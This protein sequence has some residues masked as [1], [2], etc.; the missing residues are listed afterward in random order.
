MENRKFVVIW[1]FILHFPILTFYGFRDLSSFFP[2]S[3]KREKLTL[4]LHPFFKIIFRSNYLLK[5]ERNTLNEFCTR[6]L[7]C[8]PE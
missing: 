4:G 3:M 6:D 2:L 7:A 8:T 5:L 1:E